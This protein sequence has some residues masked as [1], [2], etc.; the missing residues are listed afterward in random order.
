MWLTT[1]CDK[2]INFIAF[3]RVGLA[4]KLRRNQ[5][6]LMSCTVLDDTQDE[7]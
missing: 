2:N 3:I 7:E 1:K 5:P 4:I 6:K